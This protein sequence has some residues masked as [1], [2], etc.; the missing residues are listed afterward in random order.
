MSELLSASKREF[1]MEAARQGTPPSPVEVARRQYDLMAPWHIRDG[2]WRELVGLGHW[3]GKKK[4]ARNNSRDTGKS[5]GVGLSILW[6]AE[7]VI[8]YIPGLRHENKRA[9]V[10][11]RDENHLRQENF[12]TLENMICQYAPWLKTPD[13][14]YWNEPDALREFKIKNRTWT[15]TQKDLTNGVSLRGYGFGQSIRGLHGPLVVLDDFIDDEDAHHGKV[16]FDRINSAIMPAIIKGGMALAVGTPIDDNDVWSFIEKEDEWGFRR[17]PALDQGERDPE[18]GIPLY[19]YREKNEMDIDLGYLPATAIKRPEDL[20][21]LWPHR[22]NFGDLRSIRGKTPQTELTFLREYLM[23]RAASWNLLVHPEHFRA[24][25]RHDQHYYQRLDSAKSGYTFMGVDP[26]TLVRS[27]FVMYVGMKVPVTN[28]EGRVTNNVIRILHVDVIEIK[29]NE[30]P[31]VRKRRVLEA[32]NRIRIIF[33]QFNPK[34]IVVEGNGFQNFIQPHLEEKDVRLRG[35]IE[36]ITLTTNKHMDDGWP[37]IRNIFESGLIELPYGA[38]PNERVLIE[39]GELDVKSVQARTLTDKLWGQLQAVK[40]VDGRILEDE[41]AQRDMVAALYFMLRAAD[42][43]PASVGVAGVPLEG[44]G[45]VLARS[46][47]PE[48]K[49]FDPEFGDKMRRRDALSQYQRAARLD[50]NHR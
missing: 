35:R 42:Y 13:E 8:P 1:W 11:G 49:R 48:K 44:A 4:R 40:Y 3:P 30:A 36:P 19:G 18:T 7:Y 6:A 17:F 10:I 46:L 22:L 47:A 16:H 25:K 50:R 33:E 45:Q 28:E 26:S 32:V 41:K 31:D 2:I 27:D 21:C 14:S 43:V 15:T 39:Q 5:I 29:P 20:D 37:L 9:V 24:A 38:T 12:D 34:K 23:T